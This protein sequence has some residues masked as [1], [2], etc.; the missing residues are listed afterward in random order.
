MNHIVKTNC[1]FIRGY[2]EA[3]GVFF[4]RITGGTA[5]RTRPYIWTWKQL[6][7]PNVTVQIFGPGYEPALRIPSGDEYDSGRETLTILP[8]DRALTVRITEGDG[9]RDQ[10]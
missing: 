1:N 7:F 9:Y 4:S 3:P 8:E 6:L 5:A 10:L 2:S